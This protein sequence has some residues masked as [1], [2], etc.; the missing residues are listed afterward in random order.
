M[1][2]EKFDDNMSEMMVDIDASEAFCR[3]EEQQPQQEQ[4]EEQLENLMNVGE[5]ST[6]QLSTL[7]PL[8]REE[9]VVPNVMDY[10]EQDDSLV[11]VLQNAFRYEQR[12][13]LQTRRNLEDSGI[14]TITSMQIEEINTDEEIA[15]TNRNNNTEIKEVSMEQENEHEPIPTKINTPPVVDHQTE[16]IDSGRSELVEVT[17]GND[18]A[19]LTKHSDSLHSPDTGKFTENFVGHQTIQLQDAG[20]FLR[21]LSHYSKCFDRESYYILNPSAIGKSISASEEFTSTHRMLTRSAAKAAKLASSSSN[22]DKTPEKRKRSEVSP[23]SS[24]NAT[25]ARTLSAKSKSKK[26]NF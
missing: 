11:N 7:E 12:G 22:A 14:F 10:G 5:I 25:S 1:A 18:H 8:F 17:V 9:Y 24:C 4:Q 2:E 21:W 15:G 23:T 26:L 3:Q 16:I 13:M 19:V 20:C 6:I